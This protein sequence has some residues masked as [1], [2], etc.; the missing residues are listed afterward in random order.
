MT[1]GY[2]C[3]RD[4]PL[5]IVTV[6]RAVPL[7][8]QHPVSRETVIRDDSRL[9]TSLGLLLSRGSRCSA[10]L[11]IEALLEAQNVVLQ[12]RLAGSLAFDDDFQLDEEWEIDD[13]EEEE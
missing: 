2:F 11:A 1:D 10:E 13:E 3:F 5:G 12:A 9:R 8:Q 6:R 4:R 7:S